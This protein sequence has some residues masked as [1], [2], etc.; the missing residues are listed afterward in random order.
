MKS[1]TITA[2]L[3]SSL[4]GSA[5][6]MTACQSSATASAP[7][8]SAKMTPVAKTTAQPVTLDL[9]A[10]QVLQL[11]MP[12]ARAGNAAK[13]ARQAYY[14][15]AITLAEQ[16][17]DE[18]LGGLSVTETVVGK[19]KPSALVFYAFPDEASRDRFEAH[20]DWPGYKAQ[21]PDGWDALMIYSTTITEDLTLQFNP[22]KHYTLAVAWTN[23]ENPDDYATY[24][25]GVETDFDRVGARF[26][27]EFKDI[28]YETNNDPNV[29]APT[30]LTLVEWDTRE[31]LMSLLGGEAY[32]ANADYFQRGVAEFQFY[33]LEV[34]KSS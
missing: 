11:A 31:G 27:H 21:R 10:G 29:T 32:K 18:R 4:L 26:M 19:A 28:G 13:A 22:D 5:V 17:G 2:L 6:M 16:F 23:P 14:A 20:P 33:R 24:L 25:D 1:I 3:T 15:D 7:S 12:K 34:P 9:K 30:Q 8:Q